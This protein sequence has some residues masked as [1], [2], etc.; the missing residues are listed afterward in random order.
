MAI[1]MPH[2]LGIGDAPMGGR[3]TEY[4][5]V[6]KQARKTKQTDHRMDSADSM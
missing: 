4:D 3:P 5:K 1:A 6:H 2:R